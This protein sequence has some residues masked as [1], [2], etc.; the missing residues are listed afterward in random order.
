M[1]GA[2]AGK[3]AI[4]G[5]DLATNQQIT[6]I[7]PK[8]SIFNVFLY[9]ALKFFKNQLLEL[10]GTTTFKHINQKKLANL[11]IPLPPFE[12]PKKSCRTP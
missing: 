11:D 8:G 9:Y 4:A 1:T 6:S 2:T 5:L 3:V 12:E 10:G 7:I